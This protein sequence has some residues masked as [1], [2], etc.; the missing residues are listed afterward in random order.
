MGC[1]E[2][3]PELRGPQ[4]EL[5]RKPGWPSSELGGEWSS[6]W[7][8]AHRKRC[9]QGSV[10]QPILLRVFIDDLYERI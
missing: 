2:E 6:G 3:L 10:W 9:P 5:E 4:R 7:Q 8:V 1:T